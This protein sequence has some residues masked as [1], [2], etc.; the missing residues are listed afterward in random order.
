MQRIPTNSRLPN[1]FVAQW[2]KFKNTTELRALVWSLRE[3]KDPGN[4]REEDISHDDDSLRKELVDER[5]SVPS[6]EVTVAITHVQVFE[7]HERVV[8]RQ[9]T[10]AKVAS[11]LIQG[12]L[13]QATSNSNSSNPNLP[14]APSGQLAGLSLSSTDQ[15]I[16]GLANELSVSRAAVE[17]VSQGRF[18]YGWMFRPSQALMN[19]E[20]ITIDGNHIKI[21]S[22]SSRKQYQD[23]QDQIRCQAALNR[24]RRAFNISDAR[25]DGLYDDY[26]RDDVWPHATLLGVNAIDVLLR[27]EAAAAKTHVFPPSASTLARLA[28]LAPKYAKAGDLCRRCFKM[29]HS[30]DD[31]TRREVDPVAEA[32]L[33]RR[34][35][36]PDRDQGPVCPD[37]IKPGARCKLS[38]KNCPK[39]HWC[40]ICKRNKSHKDSCRNK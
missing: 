31:C 16:L 37:F 17:Q 19:T 36:R 40:S 3:L 9:A 33:P 27:S 12:R 21:S 29:G 22:R 7:A 2:D 28:I 39:R 1:G 15:K 38:H 35:L 4:T 11:A 14:G 10:E 25:H 8:K 20:S 6:L 32:P 23:Q 5:A 18:V 30:T 34:S 24:V 26:L 13:A